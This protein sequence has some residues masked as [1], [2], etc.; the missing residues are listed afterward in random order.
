MLHGCCKEPV[1]RTHKF[2]T[3]QEYAASC[4]L[5]IWKL[6]RITYCSS[7]NAWFAFLLE[8]RIN[9][10]HSLLFYSVIIA[11]GALAA[12]LAANASQFH[13]PEEIGRIESPR[14]LNLF[15]LEPTMID[16]RYYTSGRCERR[17]NVGNVLPP[18]AEIPDS[19]PAPVKAAVQGVPA[20][21]VTPSAV[22]V[23]APTVPI[24][25]A[26]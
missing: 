9:L 21:V 18:G 17:Q 12:P 14:D 20:R 13:M 23:K 4:V 8:G 5:G 16:E 19:D 2:F 11:I 26:K 3:S 24:A 25:P 10:K 22:P 6:D 7:V 1:D 15:Q